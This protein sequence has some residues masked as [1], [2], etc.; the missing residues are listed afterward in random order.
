MILEFQRFALLSLLL[1]VLQVPVFAQNTT[2]AKTASR[3]EIGLGF[4]GL[5]F[6]SSNSFSAF[7]KKEIKENVYRRLSFFAGNLNILHNNG[8]QT[9]FDGSVGIGIGRE[10]R[11]ALDEKLWFYSGPQWNLNVGV[12]ASSANQVDYQTY[13]FST[14]VG[15]ILGF[16]HN[17]N[18][19]WGINLETIPALSVNYQ[20]DN[21]TG[22]TA[23]TFSAN[24]FLSNTVR[25]GIVRRF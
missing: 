22:T 24:A 25:V 10:K 13:N 7:Y 5:N 6:N 21:R 15:Y 3:K 1:L 11:K 17:F 19:R 20:W 23:K 8:S 9:R 18:D 14:G 4:S 2:D 12:F 16:Q